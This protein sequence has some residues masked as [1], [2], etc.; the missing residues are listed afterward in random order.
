MTWVFAAL[1]TALGQAWIDFDGTCP[2]VGGGPLA[3]ARAGSREADVRHEAGT[4]HRAGE[5][6][7]GGRGR[8]KFSSARC[9]GREFRARS[10]P[11]LAYVVIIPCDY[12]VTLAKDGHPR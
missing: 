1:V 11:P 8:V 5:T 10:G 6:P 2:L 7:D 9:G 3:E 4:G 12:R